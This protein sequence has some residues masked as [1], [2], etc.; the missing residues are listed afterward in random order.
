MMNPNRL[1]TPQ[2]EQAPNTSELAPH[3]I[4]AIP[5]NAEVIDTVKDSAG[6]TYPVQAHIT[7]PAE[8]TKTAVILSQSSLRF[9]LARKE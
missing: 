9:R 7:L 1:Q 3:T 6:K 8:T 2:A 4:V 5:L